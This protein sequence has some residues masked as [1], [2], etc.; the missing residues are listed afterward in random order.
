MADPVTPALI[1]AL[2][3]SGLDT[4]DIVE[5]LRLRRQDEA[6]IVKMLERA[7]IEEATAQHGSAA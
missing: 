4:M 6:L 3:R 1:L 2:F 5:R 7:R